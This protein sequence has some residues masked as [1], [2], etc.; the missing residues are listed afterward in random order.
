MSPLDGPA[1]DR[2]SSQPPLSVADLLS[3]YTAEFIQRNRRQAV[4]QV[5]S[6]L[7]KLSVCRTAALGGRKWQCSSCRHECI[8]YNSCGDRHCP[9]CGGARRADWLDK[10]TDLLL[11]KV[12][13]FQVVFTLP[14]LLSALALGHRREV[15]ALLMRSAWR[16]LRDV[17]RQTQGIEPA[18]LMVLHTWNQELDH[19]VHVHALV[20]G[21]GPSL[22]GTRWVTTR[23]LRHRRRRKPYLVDNVLL[24][25]RFRENFV[26]GLKRLHARQPIAFQPP[27]LPGAD[28]PDFDEWLER[29]AVPAWN[30]FIEPPPEHAQPAHMVKYL[31]RY[32]TGGPISDGRLISHAD[33]R[34][35][36]WARSKNKAQGNPPRPF[37]LPGVEFVRR[38]SLHILPKGFTK[39]RSYG[40]F[41]C[42]QRQEYL[43]RCRQ[44]LQL[45]ESETEPPSSTEGESPET[46]RRCPRCDGTLECVSETPRPS[47]RDVF[48]DGA[49]CPWWYQPALSLRRSVPARHL[50][51]HIRGPTATSMACP[52]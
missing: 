45:A 17:L 40:G 18:A 33:G 43:Q 19:H 23:H 30:V 13:Y 8:V 26:A 44:L 46:P 48:A 2:G 52:A 28:A 27:E 15:Y 49:T 20:P 31:A 51:T 12:N 34:I 3:A 42:R 47:W 5:Q 24:S 1:G 36:F 7:A 39:T 41:S 6:T 16:A 38:W 50:P 9:R 25:Q 21:G 14:D 32:L 35:T 11:P 37:S 22:D 10:T 4:P 29:M